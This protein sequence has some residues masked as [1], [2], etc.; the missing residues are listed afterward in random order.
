MTKKFDQLD[1]ARKPSIENSEE[2]G[3]IQLLL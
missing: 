1:S 3:P 2:R